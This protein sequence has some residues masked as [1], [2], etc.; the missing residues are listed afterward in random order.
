MTPFAILHLDGLDF[1]GAFK[2]KDGYGII[3]R[4]A[5]RWDKD[6]SPIWEDSDW[7]C[8]MY[9]RWDGC[10]N[11]NIGSPGCMHHVCGANDMKRT[12]AMLKWAWN[13]CVD[14][15]VA[16][17]FTLDDDLAKIED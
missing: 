16:E 11:M 2:D 17:G 3:I 6:N 15:K 14:I 4:E 13:L 5:D 10:G 9:V 7:V 8:S 12:L 1:F